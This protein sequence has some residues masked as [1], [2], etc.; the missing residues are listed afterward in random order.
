M[1]NNK[2]ECFGDID[3]V[4]PMTENGYR[5]SPENCIKNC[6][7]KR[8]CIVKALE[9]DKGIDKKSE[10]L[11]DAYEA[12]NINFFARWAKKKSLE[13]RKKKRKD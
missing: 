7:F 12:G 3:S 11:D 6:S 8:E 4:F 2:P 1:G 9:S 5:E 10:M 13:N